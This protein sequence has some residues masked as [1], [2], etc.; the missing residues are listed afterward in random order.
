MAQPLGGRFNGVRHRIRLGSGKL[1]PRQTGLGKLRAKRSQLGF[2]EGGF[3]GTKL[4]RH[5]W[6]ASQTGLQ[7][8]NEQTEDAPEYSDEHERQE[9]KA[10]TR[11]AC[12]LAQSGVAMVTPG[13]EI[14]HQFFIGRRLR[15][16][17]RFFQTLPPTMQIKLPHTLVII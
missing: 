6:A 12:F 16:R 14:G 7:L 17:V 15:R 1:E 13:R 9:N 8:R 4:S 10:V 11:H 5:Q 3:H 2:N